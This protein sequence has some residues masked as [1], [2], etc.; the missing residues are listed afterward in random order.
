VR[1]ERPQST[2]LRGG[3][4]V[5]FIVRWPAKITAGSTCDTTINLT[6]LYATC[7]VLTGQKIDINQGVDSYSMLDL[8]IG[9]SIYDRPSSVYTDYGG[10][11]AIRKSDWKLLLNSNL[12]Q[13]QLFNLKD[14]LMNE[15]TAVVEKGRTTAGPSLEN[16]GPKHWDQLFWIERTRP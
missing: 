16:D 5:P 9:G 12:K 11:F 10:K 4:R 3:H 8:M 1:I 14:N 7:A 6:D 2:T 13:I 15:I